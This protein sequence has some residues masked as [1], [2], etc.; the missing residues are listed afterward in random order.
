MIANDIHAHQPSID[1]LN[2]AG[3]KLIEGHHVE[4]PEA[5]QQKLDDLNT[6]WIDL[7]SKLSAKAAELDNAKKDA[8]SFAHQVHDWLRWLNDVD[9]VL[10]SNKAVGGLPETAQE[11]LDKFLVSKKNF[12][13]V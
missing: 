2:D 7:Q 1:T 5:T 11:Q 12:V 10:S 6:K 4:S 9:S 13:C 3:R 8:E